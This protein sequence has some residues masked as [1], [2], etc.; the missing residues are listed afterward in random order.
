MTLRLYDSQ[1]RTL[2]DFVP[3]VPGRVGVYVCG[4]T[5]QSSPHI[6]HLRSA[7]AYDQLRRWFS[8]SGLDVTLVRNVTDIDDKVLVN[9]AASGEE[10]WALAYRT[11]LEFTAAYTAIG[12]MPPTYEPRA[13]A[14]IPE[15]Q[16]IIGRLVDAGHAYA[17]ADG[18]GDVYFDTVSWPSYGELTHQKLSDM[19]SAEDSDPRGKHDVRDFALWKGHKE[20]EPATASWQSPWGAGRPGWHIECSAMSTKYLGTQFDIHGGGLDLRFPHHENELAQ[21]RAAGDAFANYWLHNGLVSVTGQKMSKS[22]GNSVFAADLLA[23][24]RPLVVRYYLGSAHYRSTLEF[25]DGSLAEAEAALGRIEGFLDRAVRRLEGTRFST[26]IVEV[27]PEAFRTAMDDDLGVPQALGVL[28]E[29]VRDGNTALDAEDFAEAARLLGHVFA[30]TSIL[31]INPHDPAWASDDQSQTGTA[32]KALIEQ[33]LEDRQTARKA[34][35]FATA[36]RIRDELGQAG[37]TIEDTSTG[38]HWSFDG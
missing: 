8:Y 18:S 11:E 34:R 30:M 37:I 20:G 28:H 5:V 26:D 9:A 3:L 33:L 21:S 23:A 25:Q 14:S 29:A 6:G 10:W 13:T 1:A 38:A 15:M 2:R 12:V 19:A 27:V 4:P 35:D 7:L 16:S 36:D 22:L 31:G 32:L 24:A 17:A